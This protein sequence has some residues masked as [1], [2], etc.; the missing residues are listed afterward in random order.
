MRDKVIE[1]MHQSQID[2]ANDQVAKGNLD[3]GHIEKTF[4]IAKTES[5][6]SAS[7]LLF[8]LAEDLMITGLRNY[9]NS[10]VNGGWQSVTQGNGTL[11]TASDRITI[12]ELLY[13]IRQSTGADLRLLK[14]I[15]NR[16]AHH[17]DV[18]SFDDQTIS[19]YIGT[20]SK[21]EVAPLE[22]IKNAD[23]DTWRELDSHETYLVR[24][25]GTIVDLS[26]DLLYGPISTKHRVNPT[27]VYTRDFDNLPDNIQGAFR[28][29]SKMI[30]DLVSPE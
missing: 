23:A 26:I 9:L 11:A 8:S 19:G 24:A 25:L 29:Y 4:E 28:S 15:R 10:K 27:D 7:I 3:I 20:L 2:L 12:L 21:R 5:A 22:A 1:A 16:F 17:A 6:R 14:S 18:H 13:W 30:L